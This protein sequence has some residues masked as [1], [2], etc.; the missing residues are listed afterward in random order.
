MGNSNNPPSQVSQNATLQS[1]KSLKD[2]PPSVRQS[3][4]ATKQS[5]TKQ[6]EQGK[7]LQQSLHHVKI[8]AT[9]KAPKDAHT[10]AHTTGGKIPLKPSNFVNN[11]EASHQHKSNRAALARAKDSIDDMQLNGKK[12]A[13]NNG[14]KL[15]TLTTAVPRTNSQATIA[16]YDAYTLQLPEYLNRPIVVQRQR[17]MGQIKKLKRSESPTYPLNSKETPYLQKKQ[18]QLHQAIRKVRNSAT[19]PV[20]AAAL[21]RNASHCQMHTSTMIMPM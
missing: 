14:G 1:L 16:T 21:H 18:A 4:R 6:G 3:Q 20:P 8:T 2:R 17:M 7:Q 19:D 11:L 15:S 9:Q 13:Q 5:K 12:S 10:V